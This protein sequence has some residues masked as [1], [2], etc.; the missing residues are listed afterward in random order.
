M[1]T[2]TTTLPQPDFTLSVSPASQPV[3][4]G[5]GIAYTVTITRLGGFSGS[6][7]LS[8]SG[9][10]NRANAS[11]SPNPVPS[12]GTNSTM[13]VTT[14]SR[15]QAGTYTLNVTGKSGSLSHSYQVNLV[16][17]A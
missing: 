7:R 10:P 9:L 3:T 2:T 11:F 1:P 13:S 5:G 4:A 12:P 14:N 15:T 6:V 8:A 16:V 17:Q